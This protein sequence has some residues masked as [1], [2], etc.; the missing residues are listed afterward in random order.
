LT[1]SGTY[2]DYREG[3]SFK[4]DW[5]EKG[6]LGGNNDECKIQKKITGNTIFLEVE[7]I[8]G[9]D[10][11][12]YIEWN[13]GQERAKSTEHIS[14]KIEAGNVNDPKTYKIVEISYNEDFYNEEKDSWYIKETKTAEFVNLNLK[15]TPGYS[16]RYTFK[17][18]GT[19][20]SSANVNSIKWEEK[21]YGSDGTESGR[22]S[23]NLS[24]CTPVSTD[25]IT[26][27]IY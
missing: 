3:S 15:Y 23:F 26:I 8:Y 12:H 21:H 9:G 13:G 22:F 16:D 4:T 1:C 2:Y 7:N 14:L 19:D 24:S 18:S 5:P 17:Q 11:Y 25:Y 20:I 6:G 10:E 27:T